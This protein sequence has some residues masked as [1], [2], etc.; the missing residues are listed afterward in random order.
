MPLSKCLLRLSDLENS[1]KQ[2]WH[3]YD[4]PMM[5]V[6][7]KMNEIQWWCRLYN[8]REKMLSSSD[9]LGCFYTFFPVRV[10]YPLFHCWRFLR[11]TLG[12]TKVCWTKFYATMLTVFSW[13][14]FSEF[15]TQFSTQSFHEVAHLCITSPVFAMFLRYWQVNVFRNISGC[16]FLRHACF[17]SFI[18]M[19]KCVYVI[20]IH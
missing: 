17:A 6:V 15:A 2:L 19:T 20:R 11:H 9:L 14:A 5:S 12:F 10:R 18:K 13:S 16:R 1:R 8:K 3:L 7:R 4:P